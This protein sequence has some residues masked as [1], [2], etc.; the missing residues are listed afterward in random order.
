MKDGT[1]A[2]LLLGAAV[3]G[4]GMLAA[5][6]QNNEERR[7][8]FLERLVTNLRAHDLICASATFGRAAGNVPVWRV[9]LRTPDGGVRTVRIVL[10]AGTEPYADVTCDVVVARVVEEAS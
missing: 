10:P 6:Y 2:S 8:V 5:A 1:F 3:A 4:V 9:T 7:E